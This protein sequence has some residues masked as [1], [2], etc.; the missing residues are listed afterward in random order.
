[1]VSPTVL[2]ESP[3]ADEKALFVLRMGKLC[4]RAS[5]MS[6]MVNSAPLSGYT[7]ISLSP[8][9]AMII[10]GLFLV[11][12]FVMKLIVV[13]IVSYPKS[14]TWFILFIYLFFLLGGR[15]GMPYNY[16]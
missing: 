8:A 2:I 1:M 14:P 6:I 5:L 10:K 11:I 3:L 7:T 15:P 12:A 16:I 9:R 13:G 4:F